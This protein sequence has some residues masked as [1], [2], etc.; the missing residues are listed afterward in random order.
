M[1][2]M[3]AQKKYRPSLGFERKD[4]KP[5]KYTV[6]PGSVSTYHL[7]INTN[8]DWRKMSEEE[9][10]ERK[11]ELRRCL[12]V[13]KAGLED[14]GPNGLRS[15]NPES[16]LVEFSANLEVGSMMG[17]AHCD[18]IIRF[19]SFTRLN[20]AKI[21]TTLFECLGYKPHVCIRYVPDLVAIARNYS[22]KEQREKLI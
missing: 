8:Q 1:I 17:R 12:A 19:D 2:G 6:R 3:K 18:G 10:K 20:Y 16:K 14:G 5:A 7:G 22:E 4:K 13:L 9:Q 21:H 11:G 15:F